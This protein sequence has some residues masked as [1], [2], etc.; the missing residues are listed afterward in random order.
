MRGAEA[1][2]VIGTWIVPLKFLRPISFCQAGDMN[3]FGWSL[4]WLVYTFDFESF[5]RLAGMRCI[6]LITAG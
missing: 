2:V 1:C 4:Y 5:F 3:C 6:V